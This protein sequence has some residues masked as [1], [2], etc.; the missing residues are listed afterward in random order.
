MGSFPLDGS[1]EDTLCRYVAYIG[2]LS[3]EFNPNFP[4][5]QDKHTNITRQSGPAMQPPVSRM[6]IN[7]RKRKVFAAV[8]MAIS[9]G[10]CASSDQWR[11]KFAEKPKP[12]PSE[13]P[14]GVT[15]N[16]V[17]AVA[18]LPAS[19]TQIQPVA[20]RDGAMVA[21]PQTDPAEN[22]QEPEQD[23]SSDEARQLPTPNMSISSSQSVDH[24]VGL[25]LAGHPSI[26]AARQRVSAEVN[27]IP[28][29]RALPD[30]MF[31]NTFFP[32]H[33]Q[34]IQTAAGR[35]GNQ[36]ALSQSVPWPEKLRTKAAIVSQE[37]QIAQAEV[38]RIEREIAESVRLAYYEV[39]FATRA[40]AIIT[41][42]KGL[43]D[44]LTKVAEARYRSGGTQQDV[45]RTTRV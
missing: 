37:V 6:S 5:R 3:D 23:K 32:L 17:L 29:A 2:D 28:Q 41:E 24:F 8:L 22:A 11:A 40:T 39:W 14:G 13:V 25:A 36:M 19:G 20:Y 34:S 44:D 42:T 10:G 43:V 7:R 33:D 38:N 16:E 1:D 15:G 12:Q 31:N 30:P 21:A 18:S 35:V 45:L 27:R 26:Q 9:V 4:I